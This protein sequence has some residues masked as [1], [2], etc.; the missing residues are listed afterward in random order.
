M[1][2]GWSSVMSAKF[3]WQN[4]IPFMGLGTRS[5][6]LWK[7]STD[8]MIRP[9][10]RS[11]DRGGSSGC[12]AISTPYCSATGVTLSRNSCR[13]SH[14]RLSDTSPASVIGAFFIMAWS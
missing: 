8:R 4:V 12:M 7:L 10:P 14:N 13:V 2:A 11:G 6:S 5:R 9:I 1:A 3:P